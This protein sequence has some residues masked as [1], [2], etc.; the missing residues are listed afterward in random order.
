[1]MVDSVE[2]KVTFKS[3]V[4]DQVF[5]LSEHYQNGEHEHP[6]RVAAVA[7]VAL[8]CQPREEDHGPATLD[9]KLG[10]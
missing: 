9:W 1:M 10:T 8:C 6:A 5:F 7:T 2:G 3:S 4:R